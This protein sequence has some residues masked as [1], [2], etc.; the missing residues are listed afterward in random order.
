MTSQSEQIPKRNSPEPAE[1]WIPADPSGKGRARRLSTG[2]LLLA[3]F[4][5]VI[6]AV[7]LGFTIVLALL[8]FYS[9]MI[10]P[11]VHVMG[12][13]VGSMTRAEATAVLQDRWQQQQVILEHSDG[14]WP[15]RAADLGLSLD[16]AATAAQAYAQG[17]S[18]DSVLDLLQGGLHR[19]PVWSFDPEAAASYLAT[20][21]PQLSIP[22]SNAGVRIEQGEVLE[23]PAT[24]GRALD[25][26][27]TMAYLTSDPAQVLQSGHLPLATQP[28]PASVTDVSKLAEEARRL[29]A[30]AVTLR[31][32]DPIIDETTEWIISPGSWQT[33]LSLTP[34]PNDNDPFE[35]AVDQNAAA[36]FLETQLPGI[37]EDR[38]LD[39]ETLI[40]TLKTAIVTQQ[41]LVSARIFHHP[42]QHV[43]QAGETL[44][45]IGRTYGIPYPWIQ[46]ANP[47][48]EFLQAGDTIIVPSA[49]EMLPLPVVENK[50]IVISISQQRV[51]AYEDGQSRWEWPASTGI[52]DSPTA[53]GIFQIQSHEPNAY[54][55]NW[56]LWMPNFMGIYRPVPT[57]DF[58]NGFHGFPT[59]N[60]STL[61]W[62]GDLGHQV[63]YGCVLL[64]SENASLLYDWAEEGVVVEIQP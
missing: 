16:A 33:W 22:P 49:D 63:T 42:R 51:W 44:S 58:M 29:L 23:I 31:A 24:E 64:S 60:G 59:R 54:A 9:D 61:L 11:G 12:V 43:V 38:Y 3:G 55:S 18:L 32:Y 1:V 50:R 62:T 4:F 39:S 46:Q 57:S 27:R 35:W 5:A 17:R 36:L 48:S 21:A 6:T 25:M 37:G 34:G 40:P 2:K 53:P 14:T 7:I 41:P 8:F 45:A 28:V 20:I 26:D 56:D 30:T 52:D 10:V 19:Q 47:D 13:N 15:V